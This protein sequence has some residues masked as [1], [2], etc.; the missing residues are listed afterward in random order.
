MFNAL[1]KKSTAR[2]S[3]PQLRHLEKYTAQ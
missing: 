3:S 1:L 2:I